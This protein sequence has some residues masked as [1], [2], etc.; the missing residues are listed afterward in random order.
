MQ[1]LASRTGGH[2]VVEQ[3]PLIARAGI[4][5]WGGIGGP[6]QVA[7]GLKSQYDPKGILNPGR[8]AGLI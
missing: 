4:D 1:G 3:A 5:V 7:R 2:L 8:F 6:E